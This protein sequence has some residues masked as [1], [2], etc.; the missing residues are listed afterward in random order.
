ML[1]ASCLISLCPSSWLPLSALG[2]VVI[3]IVIAIAIAIAI[4]GRGG[5]VTLS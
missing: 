1:D 3:V 2:R 4:A 5:V